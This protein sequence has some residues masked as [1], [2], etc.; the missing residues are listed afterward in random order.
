MACDDNAVLFIA[1]S[2]A[3]TEDGVGI[4]LSD[5]DHLSHIHHPTWLHGLVVLLEKYKDK[6]TRCERFC[7][8]EFTAE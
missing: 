8:L 2:I 1:T 5:S 7:A 4:H 3:G 6:G